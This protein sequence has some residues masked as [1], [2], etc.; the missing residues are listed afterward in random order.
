MT[1]GV[2]VSSRNTADGEV[3][4]NAVEAERTVR[5]NKHSSVQSIVPTQ[6]DYTAR[7]CSG[8]IRPKHVRW[9]PLIAHQPEHAVPSWNTVV[10]PSWRG[11]DGT[12]CRA[13][14]KQSYNG[15]VSCVGLTQSESR[16]K[17]CREPVARLADALHPVWLH[18]SYFSKK[19]LQSV[20]VQSWRQTVPAVKG[21]LMKCWAEHKRTPH[22]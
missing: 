15:V 18:W 5:L 12:T 13:R 2:P 11:M 19:M 6:T 22:F 14:V 8:H 3:R 1:R 10:A 17:S 16:S 4:E 7:R 21:A 20:D 9:K